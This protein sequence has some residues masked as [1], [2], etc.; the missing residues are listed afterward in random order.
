[1]RQAAQ[2]F[3]P[4]PLVALFRTVGHFYCCAYCCIANR[5]RRRQGHCRT[6]H[7]GDAT[8][9]LGVLIREKMPVGERPGVGW[10]GRSSGR[11][12][13]NLS[14]LVGSK[15][16]RFCYSGGICRRPGPTAPDGGIYPI[17]NKKRGAL[18]LGDR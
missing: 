4:R 12:D 13:A 7:A 8:N 10:I 18:T 6:H 14:R 17:I 16:P 11:L 3:I 2:L 5:A 9:R 1:L 15:S